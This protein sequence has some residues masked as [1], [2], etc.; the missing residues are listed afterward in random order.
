[1][2]VEQLEIGS[3]D[4]LAFDTWD[5]R[6]FAGVRRSGRASSPGGLP[7]G[8]RGQTRAFGPTN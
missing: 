8:N 5:G 3:Q 4:E 6:A 1:V 7:R 2:V